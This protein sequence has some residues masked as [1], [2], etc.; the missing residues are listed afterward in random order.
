MQ[1]HKNV[2]KNVEKYVKKYYVGVGN[3]TLA[4]MCVSWPHENAVQGIGHRCSKAVICIEVEIR[5]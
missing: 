3:R 1:I 4:N 5:S 2:C